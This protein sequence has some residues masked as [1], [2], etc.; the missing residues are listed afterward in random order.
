MTEKPETFEAGLDLRWKWM[1]DPGIL[2]CQPGRPGPHGLGQYGSPAL[3]LFHRAKSP[4]LFLPPRLLDREPSPSSCKDLSFRA[5]GLSLQYV[6][7]A[8]SNEAMS[9]YTEP[10][11]SPTNQKAP[12]T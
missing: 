6:L 1:Q 11:D 3:L 4:G 5:S 2:T 12:Y 10:S 7:P 9:K 8:F